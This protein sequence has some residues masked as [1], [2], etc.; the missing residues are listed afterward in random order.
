L[1]QPGRIAPRECGSVSDKYK[2]RYILSHHPRMQVNAIRRSTHARGNGQAEACKP[3]S[4]QALIALFPVLRDGAWLVPRAL[5]SAIRAIVNRPVAAA[6]VKGSVMGA[7]CVLTGVPHP[8]LFTVLTMVLAMVPFAAWA[9]RAMA[10]LRLLV[11]GGTW[12]LRTGVSATLSFTVGVQSTDRSRHTMS[13]RLPA[14]CPILLNLRNLFF[15]HERA[16]SGR[17]RHI[18]WSAE[19]C[20]GNL[21]GP[22][23]FLV[24][25]FL[26]TNIG[27]H[28]AGDRQ[29]AG[30]C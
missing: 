5:A 25:G 12:F 4:A 19:D 6:I 28:L 9:A 24:N 20:L 7:A 22:R 17:C 1:V 30:S 2:C 18:R 10:V 15:G 8:M 11:H 3:G 14:R 29:L 27:D 26:Q 16:K 21:G 23:P 13:F